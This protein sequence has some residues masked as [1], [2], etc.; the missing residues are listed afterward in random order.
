MQIAVIALFFIAAPATLHSTL[1]E[2]LAASMQALGNWVVEARMASAMDIYNSRYF[3]VNKKLLTTFGLWPYDNPAKKFF[4]RTFLVV[5]IFISSLPQ[6]RLRSTLR[7]M[8]I[9]F[10]GSYVSI[11]CILLSYQS[12]IVS[13][14]WRK[15]YKNPKREKM[16]QEKYMNIKE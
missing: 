5:F 15:V 11:F 1:N 3:V 10:Q 13:E 12:F 7:K 9:I 6:V 16:W 8:N 2:E 14:N 4:V